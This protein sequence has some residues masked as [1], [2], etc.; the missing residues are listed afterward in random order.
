MVN[1]LEAPMSSE[2]LRD[3]L[4]KLLTEIDQLKVAGER[5]AELEQL[6]ADIE[7]RLEPE[8][9]VASED[10]LVDQVDG[11][12]TRF[13]AEHPSLSVSLKNIMMTL[14]SMGI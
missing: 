5:R 6:V 10:S 14:S 7:A 1:L 8:I 2:K 9:P 12:V 3:Q 4:E 13:E 11:L